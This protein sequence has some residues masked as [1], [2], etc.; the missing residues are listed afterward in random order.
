MD[1]DRIIDRCVILAKD[2]TNDTRIFD[3][4]LLLD[5]DENDSNS[6]VFF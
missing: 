6:W 5:N 2:N 4:I 1:V 3:Y